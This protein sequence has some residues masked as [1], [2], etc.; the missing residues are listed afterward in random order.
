[1]VIRTIALV[2]LVS[3]ALAAPAVAQSRAPQTDPDL[4]QKPD[5]SWPGLWTGELGAV[6]RYADGSGVHCT[7]RGCFSPAGADAGPLN[8]WIGQGGTV[9]GCFDLPRT[10]LLALMARAQS[11]TGRPAPDLTQCFR[12]T[13][14]ADKAQ[15]LAVAARAAGVEDSYIEGFPVPQEDPDTPDFSDTQWYLDTFEDAEGM[16]YRTVWETHGALGAGVRV[17]DIEGDFNVNHED[18]TTARYADLWPGSGTSLLDDD[19]HATAAL[20]L[21]VAQHNGYGMDGLAPDAEPMFAGLVTREYAWGV[22]PAILRQLQSLGPGDMLFLIVSVPGPR[23]MGDGN[24]G[25]LPMESQRA[26]YDAISLATDLGVIVLNAGGNGLENLDDEIYEGLFDRNLRDSGAIFVCGGIPPGRDNPAR[27]PIWF[28]N[29]GSRCDVQAYASNLPT[30]GYGQLFGE[31]EHDRLYTSA[32]G[33]TSGATP[34]VTGLATLLQSIARA[35]GKVLLPDGMRRLLV[36]TGTEQPE[37]V[38]IG[39]L[40]DGPRAAAVIDDYAVDV[41]LVVEGPPQMGQAC[42][43][44]CAE[45]LTCVEPVSGEGYCL[46]VCD[47]FQGAGCEQGLVCALQVTGDGQ[48]VVPRG[49]GAGDA[50]ATQSDCGPNTLCVQEACAPLCS[51]R[52]QRACADAEVCVPRTNLGLDW[53]ACVERPG[54]NLP[55]ILWPIGD[56]RVREGQQLDITVEATD[57]LGD[58]LTFSVSGLPRGATFDADR[59]TFSW[60]PQL[61]QQGLYQAIFRVDDPEGR[62]DQEVVR[63]FVVPGPLTARI[64][65]PI[66]GTPSSTDSPRVS[67][68]THPGVQVEVRRVG[69]EA[70]GQVLCRATAA[71]SGAFLCVCAPLQ[72]GEHTFAAVPI[73]TEGREGIASDSV[74]V[75]VDTVA[76]RTPSLTSPVS[77]RR[78]PVRFQGVAEAGTVRVFVLDQ[79]AEVLCAGDPVEEDG[80]IWSCT[81]GREHAEGE[82]AVIL[83][84]RDAAGNRSVDSDPQAFTVDLTPPVA[85]SITSPVPGQ[86]LRMD[87]ELE[88]EGESEPGTVQVTSGVLSCDVEAVGAM[89]SCALPASGPGEQVIEAVVTDAAGNVGPAA[90]VTVTRVAPAVVVSVDVPTPTQDPQ[91]TL[92]VTTSNA[93]AATVKV[94]GAEVCSVASPEADVASFTCTPPVLEPGVHDV[95]VVA[96][97]VGGASSPPFTTTFEVIAPEIV[98]P[99]TKKSGGCATAGAGRWPWLRRR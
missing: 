68:A 13:G 29:R 60:T 49:G 9:S 47:P 38:H 62:A 23:S 61:G 94:D 6:V 12:L 30:P 82:H 77:T 79:E 39:P 27:S 73:D 98:Q 99:A 51:V 93:D 59:A 69:G 35:R 14:A 89:W 33:G 88:V 36:D 66:D 84:A 1:L 85:P 54:D 53:G 50:C 15:T 70:D 3:L 65:S 21:I 42:H 48:C 11:R 80:G 74:R 81:A 86:L 83:R 18:L 87:A 44:V 31:G 25:N 58:P 55:P 22:G 24:Q 52:H 26:E 76:P 56:R 19:H 40:P 64:D 4:P 91:P 2:L 63:F 41:P 10:T 95:E 92:S 8:A 20:G 34:L 72:E 67:G 97:I 45:G 71:D 16:G 78:V 28:T 46:R 5:W 90:R 96:S 37:G 32:F 57:V 7:K 75:F 17:L 43:G